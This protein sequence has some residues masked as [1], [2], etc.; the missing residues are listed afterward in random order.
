MLGIFKAFC[1]LC[2]LFLPFLAAGE[3]F[4]NTDDLPELFA[5]AAIVIE[6]ETGQVLYAKNERQV[7]PPASL[8]KLMTLHLIYK[9][10]DE[11]RFTRE[12]LVPVSSR[13]DFENQPYGSSVMLLS[14]GNNVTLYEIMLGLAIPSGND[15][16]VAAAEAVG[17]SVENFVEAMNAEARRLGMNDTVFTDPAGI[18]D[19]NKTTAYD[20]ALFCRYYLSRHP[21]AIEELHTVEKF[22]Y[23]LPGNWGE[24]SVR[25]A[26][27]TFVNH[28]VI[29]QLY[30]YADGL[31]TGYI[32]E[33]GY[34]LA[35][36]AIKDNMRLVAVI[37]GVEAPGHTT[38]G[39]RRAEDGV[40]LFDYGF[41]HFSLANIND[42]LETERLYAPVWGG[43]ARRVSLKVPDGKAFFLIKKGDEKRVEVKPV[44][45]DTLAPVARERDIAFVEI[46]YNGT[47]TTVPLITEGDVGR[48]SFL[49]Y[50]NDRASLAVKQLV[51]GGSG[52]TVRPQTARH[53]QTTNTK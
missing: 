43:R 8:T 2:C 51:T 4:R 50:I 37:L 13:A 6:E 41:E 19:N 52:R 42:Y 46:A 15:A 40:K 28:N 34:N 21:Y 49:G 9:A 10:I 1:F 35:A 36:T 32:D 5:R 31:K 45:A 16:A 17:G 26:P 18:D 25:W 48:R 12:S 39:N 7:I 14:E 22:S 27:Y 3:S 44:I 47:K 29:L 38:G 53:S 33:S 24:A 11:G 23:P 20:F 30:P